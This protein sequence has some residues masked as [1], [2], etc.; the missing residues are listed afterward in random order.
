VY[1]DHKT[2]RG[3][4]FGRLRKQILLAWPLWTVLV[5]CFGLGLGGETVRH[6]L[7]YSRIG[8]AQ[9]QWWL[10]FTGNFVHLGW[11]HILL[12]SAG[13]VLLWIL[14]GECLRGWRWLFATI[15]GSWAVG[16]GLWW[17]W[18]NVVW[19]VGIS[20]VAHTYWAAGA[21]LLIMARRWEGYALLVF[22]AGKLAWEQASGTGLPTS[23]A[24]LSGPILTTAHL[25]GAI[26]GVVVGL[27]L[28]ACDY[29]QQRRTAPPL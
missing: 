24:L 18:P 1:F 11:M 27:A 20:G 29:W 25:I 4:A 21:L 15:A 5:I 8:V 6:A 10:L 13:L 28:I 17:A 7:R 12:D 16:L 3:F 19:Y 2:S 14:C 26:A 23:D 9:G 22:L